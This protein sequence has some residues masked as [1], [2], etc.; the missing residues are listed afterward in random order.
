MGGAW[1]LLQLCLPPVDL[2]PLQAAGAGG[3][4][5]EEDRAEHSW[6]PAGSA[7]QPV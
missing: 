1:E 2:W 5:A 7:R 4:L 3:E 6:E